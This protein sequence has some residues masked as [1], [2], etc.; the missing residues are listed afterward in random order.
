MSR[1]A[2]IIGHYVNGKDKGAVSYTGET[3]SSYNLRIA[4]KLKTSLASHSIDVKIFTR[5]E[6]ITFARISEGVKSFGAAISIELHFNSFSKAAFG[7]EC[8]ALEGDHNSISFADILTD[9][10][11]EI[12]QVSERHKNGN[13]DGVLLIAKGGRGFNNLKIVRYD[14]NIPVVLIEPCFAN[15]KT[16]DSIKFFE[17]EHLYVKSLEQ[18]VIHW[19]SGK[20]VRDLG[21]KS[22]PVSPK[23]VVEKIMN[24]VKSDYK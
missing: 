16:K 4:K 8:L 1:L 19:L 18:S 15:I 14:N 12:M 13:I 21:G 22:I 7:C 9:K 5:D 23:N 20:P 17:S 2:I 3:E 6:Y 24:S 10:I 11:S